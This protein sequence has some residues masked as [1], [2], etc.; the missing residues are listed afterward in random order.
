MNL[1]P[2]EAALHHLGEGEQ[3]RK[4]SPQTFYSF[5]CNRADL[6]RQVANSTTSLRVLVELESIH[7][8]FQNEDSLERPSKKDESLSHSYRQFSYLYYKISLL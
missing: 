2:G 1:H 5:L 4:P 6:R 7:A 8:T 3:R